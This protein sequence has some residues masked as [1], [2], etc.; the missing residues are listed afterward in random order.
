MTT[1]TNAAIV[2]TAKPKATKETISRAGDL[3]VSI[4]SHMD[5]LD[6]NTKKTARSSEQ[7]RFPSAS[8][9]LLMSH[10]DFS[11]FGG[12]SRSLGMH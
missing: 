4:L 8:R 11:F 12:S 1:K 7:I 10:S 5:I 9:G 3:S 6:T 2:I